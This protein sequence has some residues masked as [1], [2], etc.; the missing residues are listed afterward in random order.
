MAENEAVNLHRWATCQ[1]AAAPVPSVKH[2][3]AIF[4]YCVQLLY[5]VWRSVAGISAALISYRTQMILGKGVVSCA[6]VDLCLSRSRT[7]RLDGSGLGSVSFF[8]ALPSGCML[9]T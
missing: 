4:I 8:Y 2:R 1:A 6:A 3:Q 5:L 9:E 7:A